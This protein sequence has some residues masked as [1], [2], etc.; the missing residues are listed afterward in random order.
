MYFLVHKPLFYASCSS[1]FIQRGSRRPI[2]L[3]YNPSFPYNLPDYQ[4]LNTTLCRILVV[5]TYKLFILGVSKVWSRIIHCICKKNIGGWIE[6]FQNLR[7][8][9][10]PLPYTWTIWW[11]NKSLLTIVLSLNF[12]FVS[13]TF[14]C[15]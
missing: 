15:F 12:W 2:Y 10:N 3:I 14:P 9:N 7:R 4:K 6:S 8:A 11:G 1:T 5:G 13:N